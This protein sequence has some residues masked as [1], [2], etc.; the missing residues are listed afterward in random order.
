MDPTLN[1]FSEVCVKGTAA[2]SEKSLAKVISR[3][4]T[5]FRTRL[6]HCVKSSGAWMSVYGSASIQFLL[7]LC[8]EWGIFKMKRESLLQCCTLPLAH[9]AFL[10]CRP[11]FMPSSPQDVSVPLSANKRVIA[12]AL[13]HGVNML[14]R[15]TAARSPFVK[16]RETQICQHGMA[17]GIFPTAAV[18]KLLSKFQIGT[19]ELAQS[20]W[21]TFL[22]QPGFCSA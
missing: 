17:T 3:R 22:R 18:R 6:P 2:K 21:L 12:S 4:D 13:M 5:K 14:S 15:R 8:I 11:R 1:E 7:C 10:S 9:P 19:T 20:A 16:V